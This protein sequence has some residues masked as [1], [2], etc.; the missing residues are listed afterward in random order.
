MKKKII[1]VGILVLFLCIGL[2][3]CL[4]PEININELEM[5]IHNLIN[6]ERQKQGLSTLE[7]DIKLAEIA[8]T[9][10][11]DMVNRNFYSH[12]NPEGQGPTERAISA[13]F[14]T[15]GIGENICKDNLLETGYSICFIP[16]NDWKDL[17]ELAESIV[18]S[19]MGS[20][21]HRENI[22]SYM[23]YCEGIGVAISSNDEVL[24]TQD[25]C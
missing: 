3:G 22:L 11:K 15:D 19:W 25:L 23:Y 13:G 12:Y 9:H 10:S 2:S 16:L 4:K 17:G 14:Y 6:K 5:E 21:G 18:E 20:Y 7:Y 24:V 8:R 1:V